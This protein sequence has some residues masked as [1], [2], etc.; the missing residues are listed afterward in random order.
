[1]VD[2][3]LPE[4]MSRHHWRAPAGHVKVSQEEINGRLVWVAR[5]AAGVVAL[6]E[7]RRVVDEHL[8]SGG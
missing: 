3:H 7:D 5:D 2:E 4:H 1:M 8:R 6:S